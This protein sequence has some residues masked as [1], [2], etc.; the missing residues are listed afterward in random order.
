MLLQFFKESVLKYGNSL[1]VKDKHTSITYYALDRQ[2]DI[3]ASY[4]LKKNK[5]SNKTIINI[6]TRSINSIIG[7]LG[8]LKS[9][10]R[11]VSI[12]WPCT[13][14]ELEMIINAVEHDAILFSDDPENRFCSRPGVHYISSILATDQPT[15][16]ITQTEHAHGYICFTSGSTGK[17]KGVIVK[18]TSIGH[19]I[20]SVLDKLKIP[21]RLQYG[22][23]S[24][25]STDLGNTSIFLSLASGG[26]LHIMDDYIRRDPE[27][28]WKYFSEHLVNFIKTTPSHFKSLLSHPDSYKCKLEY[29]LLGGEIFEK[30]LAWEILQ[31]KRVNNLYNHYGPTEATIGVATY[32]I[33]E[34]SFG[35]LENA[36]SI[37]VGTF[38]GSNHYKLINRNPETNI[39]ELYIGG[40]QLA[41][42]YYNDYEATQKSFTRIHDEYYYKTGDLVKEHPN[43]I[44][45]FLGRVDRQVKIR[46]Y[47]VELEHV[48]VAAR[49]IPDITFAYAFTE[50]FN[51]RLRL[52]LAIKLETNDKN[53]NSILND[54]T[55][56]LPKYMLPDDIFVLDFVP[57]KSSGKANQTEIINTYKQTKEKSITFAEEMIGDFT[58]EMHKVHKEWIHFFGSVK[59]DD[60]FFEC[61][62]D[63][64][65]AIEFISKLQSANIKI[66]TKQFLDNPTVKGIL[67][68]IGQMSIVAPYHY[69]KMTNQ[70]HPVQHWYFEN[71]DSFEG[72]FNQSICISTTETISRDELYLVVNDIIKN[73]PALRTKYIKNKK[74]VEAHLVSTPNINSY[75]AYY[76][77]LEDSGTT[78]Q[79][80][81]EKHQKLIS[82]ENGLLAQ[83]L[84]IKNRIEN[85]LT[86]IIH[87]LAIDGVSWRI[88]IDEI[89]STFRRLKLN[90]KL[91]M[92]E[93]SSYTQWIGALHDYSNSRD[94]IIDKHKLEKLYKPDFNNFLCDTNMKKNTLNNYQSF[95]LSFSTHE[96]A[97]IESI[98]NDLSCPLQNYLLGCVSEFIFTLTDKNN[99]T[100]D[101]ENHGREHLSDTLDISRTIGWFTSIFPIKIARDNRAMILD[102]LSK[103]DDSNPKKGLT[104]GVLKYLKKCVHLSPQPEFCFNFLGKLAIDIEFSDTWH[105]KGISS[106]QCRNLNATPPYKMIITSKI[107]E[108]KLY[109]DICFD[110]DHYK[111]KDPASSFQELKNNLL[112]N[113]SNSSIFEPEKISI[114]QITYF[115]KQ[116]EKNNDNKVHIKEK[117]TVL[118]TGASGFVGSFI[119]KSLT[120]HTD[121]EIICILRDMPAS[122]LENY[123]LTRLDHYFPDRDNLDEICSRITLLS[124]QLDKDYFG[125]DFETYNTLASKVDLIIHSA[126]DVNLFKSQVIENNFNYMSVK[127][128]IK[129]SKFKKNKQIHHIS[130]LAVCGFV[131]MSV[132]SI[133]FTE[134]DLDIGQ[135]FNNSYEESKFLSEKLL[136]EERAN[137]GTVFIYRLGNITADSVESIYQINPASNRIFQMLKSYLL[138][139]SVPSDMEPFSL[140][141]VDIVGNAIV[142]IASSEKISG[143]TF[144]IDNPQLIEADKLVDYFRSIGIWVD[145]VSK[146]EYFLKLNSLS[147]LSNLHILSSFWSNRNQRNIKFSSEKSNDFLHDLGVNYTPVTVQWF[148]EFINKSMPEV[149]KDKELFFNDHTN[150]KILRRKP[151][152]IAKP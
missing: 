131:N 109:I 137:G 90:S 103:F 95:W 33:N 144:N 48:E 38:F 105:I 12:E 100:V 147:H 120:E 27:S 148:G 58:T 94:F 53:K 59:D 11:Y 115:N 8:I 35:T 80:I 142:K 87:H 9:G 66:T 25:L 75:I 42:S 60:H 102:Q 68:S 46:G 108:K 34:S 129:F 150:K 70:L 91:E 77:N 52:I 133:I 145:M 124:G 128:V 132:D 18:A 96:T 19:Y 10:C 2:S 21:D 32:E 82:E 127:Q 114:G 86:V 135:K 4:L 49:K 57:L 130:T 79:M 107:I 14:H 116:T 125:L 65:A 3:L 41:D 104:Y 117:K 72:W 36:R 1:A 67:N 28:L 84:F 29:L 47:R 136:K 141:H 74:N 71:C 44:I 92:R 81:A 152:I 50:I 89:I 78:P 106:G 138:T 16:I 43:S 119:L 22:Y 122:S 39:G 126:A 54:L 139:R 26:T 112:S 61:G 151:L 63:S 121:W 134:S 45:E 101:V 24:S 73:H 111:I 149:F 143:G 99:I 110:P 113:N 7:L 20:K 69:E 76:E 51:S 140:T 93:V 5:L 6:C 56:H 23:V 62:G 17:P 146:E 37:P 55:M 64:I 40:P 15:S 88:L 118:L 97:I 13:E 31:T 85:H 83:F 30:E 98:I 123:L